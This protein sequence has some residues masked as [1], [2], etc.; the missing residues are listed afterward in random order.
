MPY[1]YSGFWKNLPI[2]IFDLQDYPL[3]KSMVMP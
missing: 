2:T 1:P 3:T